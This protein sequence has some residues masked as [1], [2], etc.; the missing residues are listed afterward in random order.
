LRD[1]QVDL[2]VVDAVLLG[3]GD[4]DEQDAEDVVAVAL[5]RGSRLVLMLRR[6]EQPFKCCLLEVLR[7]FR[8]ELLRSRVE[9]VDPG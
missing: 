1:D 4:G 9:Q 3:H 2:L 7:G 6:R 8:A 5:Q